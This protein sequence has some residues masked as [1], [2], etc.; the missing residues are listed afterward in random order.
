[1]APPS[2]L[3]DS[4]IPQNPKSETG[5]YISYASSSHLY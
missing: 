4:E 2:H 5:L 3:L 1:M